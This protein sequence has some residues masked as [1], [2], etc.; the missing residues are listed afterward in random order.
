M[1]GACI[2]YRIKLAFLAPDI[3]EAIMAGQ[4][5]ADLTAQKLIR[6]VDLPMD[7]VEQRRILGFI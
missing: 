6:N 5:P 3:V 1:T 2:S 4:Q 7:W